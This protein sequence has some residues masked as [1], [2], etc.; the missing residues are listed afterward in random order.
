MDFKI[1]PKGELR[2]WREILKSQRCSLNFEGRLSSQFA[3]ATMA[4]YTGTKRVDLD[5]V[6]AT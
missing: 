2:H 3:S 4:P 6:S 5:V 1:K